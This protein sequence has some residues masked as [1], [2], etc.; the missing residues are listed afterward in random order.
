MVDKEMLSAISELLDK[1]LEQNL[2]RKFDEKLR[3]IYEGL[4]DL[5]VGVKGLKNRIKYIS[6]S[7]LIEFVIPCL[8]RIESY[9]VEEFH[10]YVE[11]PEKFYKMVADIA[12]L[13]NVVEEHSRR[14]EK[15]PE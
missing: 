7:Q 12:I 15:I 1:K 4:I 8:S 3:P 11:D 6:E 5:K 14:L 10:R 9:H 2:D 13:K